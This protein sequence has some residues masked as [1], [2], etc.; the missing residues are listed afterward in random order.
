MKFK[1]ISVV[2]P[3]LNE[4]KAIEK[5]IKEIPLDKIKAMGYETEVL[6]VDNGSTDKTGHI[7]KKN[8]AI[9]FVQPVRGYGNAYKAGF[10]N[11]HGDIIITGDSDSTYPFSD[12][13]IFLSIIEQ[14]GVDF[15]NTDRLSVLRKE[16]MRFSHVIGNKILTRF[17]KMLYPG[18]PFKDSQSGMWIFKKNIWEKLNVTSSSM[19]FS[20]ELKIEVYHKGFAVTEIPINYKPRIG[21]VKLKFRNA[22]GNTYHLFKKR[23]SLWLGK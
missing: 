14:R 20:Q 11:A 2:I 16:S 7:A 19:P 1:S 8:G 18:F 6:I 4:E 23:V 15:I 9:V 10:A 21:Q 17:C 3:A 12:I 13:P 5:V 22:F